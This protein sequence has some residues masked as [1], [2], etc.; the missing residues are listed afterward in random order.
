MTAILIAVDGPQAGEWLDA[1][2]VHAKGRGLRV[3]P[4]TIGNPDDIAYAC[5]WNPPH[6]LLAR[7]RN[8]KAIINLGAGV[9]HLLADPGLPRVSVSRVAHPDLTTRVTEYAVLHVLMHHRR[10]RLYDAQQHGRVW[11]A[12][13]QPAASEVAVGVMGLGVIGRQ[14]AAALGNI[15]FK[16]AGWSRTPKTPDKML[17][18]IETFHGQ[19]GLDAFLGRTEILVCLLPRTPDTEGILNLALFRKLKRDGAAGGAFVINAGRGPLQVD[20][21]IVSA[22]DEGALAGCTLDVFPQEPLPAASPLWRHP[23]I[24]ITPHNAG[25]ISPRVFAPHVIAQI[26]R[27]ERGLPLENAVDRTRG[28]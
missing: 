10:Q 14:V 23:K 17:A 8:L 20:A 21:D 9:D 27:F 13:D 25:D 5:V 28:Y 24:T 22:L 3:W 6:G 18:E 15:G 26:E 11:R 19:G 12:H 2:R 16:V 7:F 4:D 1:L